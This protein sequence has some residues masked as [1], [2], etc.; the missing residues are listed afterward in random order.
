MKNKKRIYRK[1]I[2]IRHG[3]YKSEPELLTAKGRKQAAIV[4][5][6]IKKIT[7]HKYY[8]SNMPRAKETARIIAGK[9]P[10]TAKKFFREQALPM[11]QKI[12]KDMPLEYRKSTLKK[13]AKEADKAFKY[14]FKRPK[15]GDKTIV[16][17]AHGN[18]IRYWLCRALDI[19]PKKWVYFD[20]SNASMTTIGINRL[21][22]FKISGF[23]E[24]QHLPLSFR[25]F[26]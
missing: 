17:V 19:D 11:P 26:M 15:S 6:R 7:I 9:K 8:S 14:L 3:Q 16:V 12:L 25:T 18:V 1:I 5:K 21:G 13:N 22:Y 4:A 2:F 23:A 10:V 24:I 20:I